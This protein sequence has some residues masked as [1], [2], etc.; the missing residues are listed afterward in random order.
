MAPILP[1]HSKEEFLLSFTEKKVLDEI[2]GILEQFWLPPHVMTQKIKENVLPPGKT[3]VQDVIVSG[4]TKNISLYLVSKYAILVIT[5]LASINDNIVLKEVYGNLSLPEDL[6]WHVF[7]ADECFLRRLSLPKV[8]L[9]N[10]CVLENFPIPRLSLSIGL[11]ASYLRKYQKAD[12]HII[13]MQVGSTVEDIIQEIRKLRPLLFGM[14]IS[15]GQK[16]LALSILKEIHRA[17]E[18]GVIN[19]LVVLGNIIPAS[20]PKEFLSVYPDSIVACGEGERT[21]IELI[22]HLNG[23]RNLTEVSGIAYA[24]P[25]GKVLRTLNTSVPMETVPLPALDTIEDIARCRGAV[26]LELSRGCQWNVCTFCPREHKSSHWKT[27]TTPQILE[28]FAYLHNICEIFNIKKHIFLADEEFMGGMNDGKETERIADVAKALIQRNSSMSFDA[29]AR[30]DQIYDPHMDKEWHIK[31]MEMW[32]RTRQAGLDRLFM[33][34]ESG[35]EAQLRR[36]GKGIK[37]EHS[38]FAIKILSALG[39]PLRFGFIT[40]DQLMIGLKDLKENI[41][42]LERTDAFM[43][44]INV[45][46][47]GYAKLFDLLVH[48]KDFVAA[49]S[50]NTPLY[51]GVSY[52]LAS[53]EVLLNSRYKVMLENAEKRFGKRLVLDADRPDTNMGRYKVEFADDLV[54]EISISCQ[55]WIDRHFGLSYAVKSL[56]K[57]A[58]KQEMVAL[59]DWMLSFRSISLFLVKALVYI[60]DLE[61]NSEYLEHISVMLQHEPSISEVKEL[62][63]RVGGN[64]TKKRSAIIEHCMNIFDGLVEQENLKLE[65]LICSNA[66]TDTENAQVASVLHRWKEK[67]GV[68]RLINDL[69]GADGQTSG[70]ATN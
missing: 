34:I 51:S 42:F 61:D 67:K 6:H 68:W 10:P 33:G 63:A 8:L 3:V 46:Q 69:S 12:V 29:A 5:P 45:E 19:S 25:S 21:I 50:A 48:D 4:E 9:V 65:L 44:Q 27:F 26:T 16:Y 43:N 28:Q 52:M 47:Y 54:R 23:E 39:I 60:F 24:H 66:I 32:H 41:D 53:M 22:E 15:Y 35:S 11:V 7:S 36:Y 58:P 13:D 18:D 62:R 70:Y 30:V 49:H 14:S 20:F 57:V 59:S 56:F 1:F 55:K 37:P 40:F 31:R 2:N 38:I 17:K 64:H